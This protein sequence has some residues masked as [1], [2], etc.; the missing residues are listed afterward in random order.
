MSAS[1]RK[2]STSRGSA[3]LSSPRQS[4]GVPS[5]TASSASSNESF[6]FDRPC[7]D[8]IS[9]GCDAIRDLLECASDAHPHRIR[10]H[11]D[12][13]ADFRVA[14]TEFQAHDDEAL[15]L[16]LELRQR[17]LE[18][19]QAFVADQ[20]LNDRLAFVGERD[21]VDVDLVAAHLALAQLGAHFVEQ[22]L[23]QIGEK[24]AAAVGLEF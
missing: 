21:G 15:I 11:A 18:A 16:A 17:T 13:E 7:I 9:F 2:A 20:L 3:K 19:A 14:H 10:L 6:P 12:V 8:A 1:K 5:A 23:A 4:T 22:Y 24:A